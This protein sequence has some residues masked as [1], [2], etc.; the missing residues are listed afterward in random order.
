MTTRYDFRVSM[1]F[2]NPVLLFLFTTLYAAVNSTYLKAT[3]IV[4]NA[5]KHS[6]LDCWEFT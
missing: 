5:A 6:A 3:A 4:T 2:S 1:Y